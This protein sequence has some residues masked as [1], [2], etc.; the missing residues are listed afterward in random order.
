MREHL[1]LL[2]PVD[3]LA[4]GTNSQMLP[5]GNVYDWGSTE[6]ELVRDPLSNKL[7]ELINDRSN[8]NTAVFKEV[9]HSLPDDDGNVSS[10]N[11]NKV[12]N[13]QTY[14]K[15]VTPTKIGHVADYK[16]DLDLIVNQLSR[17]KGHIVSMPLHYMEQEELDQPSFQINELTSI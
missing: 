1:G 10:A 6:D 12:R 8:T 3:P 13:F 17:V 5:A 9:F 2:P 4:H 7:W 11:S 14:H 15:F 16:M